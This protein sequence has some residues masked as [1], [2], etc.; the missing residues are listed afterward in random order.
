MEM[1]VSR[2]S[3]SLIFALSVAPVIAGDGL[4]PKPG[5]P[6]RLANPDVRIDEQLDSQV[7]LDLVF[8]NEDGI[9]VTLGD[10]ING[11]P[12]ILVLAYFRC[13]MNCTDVLNG[14]TDAMRQMPNDFSVGNT[15][16]VLTVSFDEREQ[17]GLAR[18]KKKFYLGDYGRPGAEQ[19]WHFLT[20]KKEPIRRLT[21]A[22]GFRFV[23]DKV[24]KEYD[25]L[26]GIIV[27]RPDGRVFRYF[28]G[29]G[30]ADEKEIRYQTTEGFKIGKTTLKMSLVEASDGQVGSFVD[31]MALRC[32]RFDH[33][34]RNYSLNVLL[35][36]RVGGILTVLV[37]CLSV[38]Y[39]VRR[40]RRAS[41]RK[42]DVLPSGVLPT[43][44]SASRLD[45]RPD[46]TEG[47]S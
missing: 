35:V 22:V 20:G 18:E 14:L 7:P 37:L 29:I 36:V 8:R 23:Y 44:T 45:A 40:E 12:T 3:L 9:D 4:A 32:F 26:S 21:E 6:R 2:F 16:N 43:D 34:E 27:L 13:P 47:L 5:E 30:Y 15:F 25:H 1:A 33:L 38:T 24:Y 39:Y 17:P 46:R 41:R 10:C 11:K 19:G 31:K 42:P 28:Y